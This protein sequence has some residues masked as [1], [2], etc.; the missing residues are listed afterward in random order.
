LIIPTGREIYIRAETQIVNTTLI[1]KCV[2]VVK[3]TTRDVTFTNLSNNKMLELA[4][5]NPSSGKGKLGY[6]PFERHYL[7]MTLK[8]KK[9]MVAKVFEKN[10]DGLAEAKKRARSHS[11]SKS[12]DQPVKTRKDKTRNSHK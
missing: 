11:R 3:M 1:G 12:S 5:V 2:Q 6:T 7:E 4:E 10:K 8:A 9:E